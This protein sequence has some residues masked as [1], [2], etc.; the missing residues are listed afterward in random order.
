VFH[1]FSLFNGESCITLLTLDQRVLSLAEINILRQR[2]STLPAHYHLVRR[3]LTVAGLIADKVNLEGHSHP[4]NN[5]SELSIE[6][7]SSPVKSLT[8]PLSILNSP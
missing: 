8:E 1:F 7:P 6:N 3:R 5:W 2:A 4:E